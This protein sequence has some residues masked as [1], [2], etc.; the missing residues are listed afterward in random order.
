MLLVTEDSF[1]STE[2]AEE[3]VRER[4]EHEEMELRGAWR[5]GYDYVHVF[6]YGPRPIA[7]RLFVP[8]NDP[9]PSDRDNHVYIHSYVLEDADDSEILAALDR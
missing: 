5:A 9:I 7:P 2:A 8:T 4:L 1:L 6:K 3:A